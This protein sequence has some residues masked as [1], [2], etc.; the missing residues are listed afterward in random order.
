M[1]ADPSRGF[2]P[3]PP[4]AG[5]IAINKS[6]C[7]NLI[8]NFEPHFIWWTQNLMCFDGPIFVFPLMKPHVFWWTQKPHVFWWTLPL[9]KPHVF[10]WTQKTHVWLIFPLLKP[11]VFWWT[12]KP[13]V[14]WWTLDLM[15][16]DGPDRSIKR[17][18]C[19]QFGLKMLQIMF[20]KMWN[21]GGCSHAIW[22]WLRPWCF[23]LKEQASLDFFL[24]ISAS[25]SEAKN[26]ACLL[27]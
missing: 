16:I 26:L 18:E 19:R 24:I 21:Y 10:W 3:A 23:I 13:H 25:A 9:L 6:S 27:C 7:A 22:K 1:F 11:H 17:H 4:V 8:Q 14:F 2:A 5:L 12:Q 15:S 20:M